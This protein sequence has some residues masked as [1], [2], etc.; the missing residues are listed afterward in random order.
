MKGHRLTIDSLLD[1]N[2]DIRS[3]RM[4]QRK[5]IWK[6]EESFDAT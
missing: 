5:S 2:C 6:V 4:P 3:R 1:G